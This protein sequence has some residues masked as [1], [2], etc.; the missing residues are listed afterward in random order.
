MISEDEYKKRL[1]EDK[2][3][4]DFEQQWEYRFPVVEYYL[5]KIQI[6]INNIPTFVKPQIPTDNWNKQLVILAFQQIKT[7]YEG[8]K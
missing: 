5:S 8:K 6:V 1:E 3:F 7:Q 4:E 2:Y